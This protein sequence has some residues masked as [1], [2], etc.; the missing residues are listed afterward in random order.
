MA[1]LLV[2]HAWFRMKSAIFGRDDVVRVTLFENDRNIS[3]HNIVKIDGIFRSTR[4]NFPGPMRNPQLNPFVARCSLNKLLIAVGPSK[5]I[6]FSV[7]VLLRMSSNCDDHFVKRPEYTYLCRYRPVI[8]VTRTSSRKKFQ[9]NHLL[10]RYSSSGS[11]RE[12][13]FSFSFLKKMKI[14]FYVRK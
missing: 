4:E 11:T 14:N 10:H 2:F 5:N 3:W 6:D 13:L 9:T 7:V 1:P 12:N 8:L